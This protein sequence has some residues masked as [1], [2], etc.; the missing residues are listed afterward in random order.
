MPTMIK[1][2]IQHVFKKISRSEKTAQ[3]DSLEQFKQ[4]SKD[5]SKEPEFLY[6]ATYKVYLYKREVPGH[7]KV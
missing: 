1:V 7:Y 5:V 6:K 3:T 4:N 2:N